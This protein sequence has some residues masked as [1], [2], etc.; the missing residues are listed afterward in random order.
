[1]ALPT[2]SHASIPAGGSAGVAI[3]IPCRG[4]IRRRHYR[5]QSIRR[6]RRAILL[7]RRR[8]FRFRIYRR[9][10][11]R[12]PAC[13]EARARAVPL[14]QFE[15]ALIAA[16]GRNLRETRGNIISRKR[17]VRDAAPAKPIA[18]AP[19]SPSAHRLG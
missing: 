6:A 2:S 11:R 7:L 13:G 15:L 14:N 1:V 10:A 17:D 5:R 9:Q 3:V 18:W 4:R 19:V 12:R 16:I 8:S